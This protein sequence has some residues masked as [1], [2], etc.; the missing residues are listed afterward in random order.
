MRIVL[1]TVARKPPSWVREGFEEY[2][3]RLPPQLTLNRIEVKPLSRVDSE[4][5]ESAK[6]RE[7]ERLREVIPGKARVIALDEHGNGWSTLELSTQLQ[8]WM[9]DGRDVA[10]LVGGADGLD[11]AILKSADAVWSLSRLTL[12]HAFVQVIVAEQIYRAW[13]VLNNHPYH[14]A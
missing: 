11:A 9:E 7:A 1:A 14:R 8:R 4:S 6:R 13:S 2:V 3:K 5:A 12:P 10:L